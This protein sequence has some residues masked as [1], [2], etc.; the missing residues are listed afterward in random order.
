MNAPSTRKSYRAICPTSKKNEFF[1][2]K[3]LEGVEKFSKTLEKDGLSP[4]F[5]HNRATLPRGLAFIDSEISGGLATK[6]LREETAV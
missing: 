4:G 6:T 5:F 1:V 3:W 2:Y